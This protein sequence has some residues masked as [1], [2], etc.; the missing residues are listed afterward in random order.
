MYPLLGLLNGVVLAAM[1]SLN[2]RLTAAWGVFVS[3]VIIH[4]VGGAAAAAYWSV[5][6]PH[7]RMWGHRPAWVYLGGALGVGTTLLQCVAILTLRLT[8]VVALG[9]LGQ[10]LC[11][12]A[13]DL[14]GLMGAARVRPR[15]TVAVSLAFA[16]VG[17][18]VMMGEGAG[19]A[20]AVVCALASGAC[21][22]TSRTVNARLAAQT[23]SETS[24]L[25]NYVTALPITLVVAA[26]TTSPAALGELAGA[27]G[28]LPAWAYAGGVLSVAVIAIY[29]AVVP[30]VSAV[31]LTLLVFAGQVMAGL[32][33]DVAL[34]GSFDASVA[35]GL[36]VTTG[37]ALKSVLD[38][39]LDRRARD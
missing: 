23:D 9:L 35:G 5:R 29:N 26:A 19:S 31:S 12:L 14:L 24:T 36:V 1:I 17:I 8:S 30:R 28:S 3:A 16:A 6:R 34:G 10:I 4:L 27:A 32:V 11:S 15:P 25:L 38:L 39:V 20:V 37:I 18:W 33:V 22:V 7:P 2:G 21:I 13:I